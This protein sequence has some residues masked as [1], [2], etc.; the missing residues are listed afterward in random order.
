MSV[1]ADLPVLPTKLAGGGI[2]VKKDI[3]EDRC[4][5]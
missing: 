3:A 5:L 4:K 2:R 1:L